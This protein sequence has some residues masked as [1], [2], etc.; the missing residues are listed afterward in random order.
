M[1]RILRTLVVFAAAALVLNSCG[2][3]ESY[4]YD[5]PAFISFTDGT[6]GAYFV[7]SDNTPYQ[8]TVGIPKALTSDLT[9]NIE[10]IATTGEAGVNYDIPTSVT[11]PAGE[12]IAQIPVKGY[13]ESLAGGVK[14]TVTFQLV[15]D[16]VASFDT[17][18]TIV[19]QQFCEF[20][21]E[22]FVGDWTAYE[23]SD[24][25]AD[26]Y[27]P[28]TVTFEANPNGGDTLV[29][30]DIWPYLP[31]KVVFDATD[32]ADFFWRIPDQYLLTHATYGDM[33]MIDLGPGAFSSCDQSMSI[34][35]KVYVAAGNFEQSSISLVKDPVV[36]K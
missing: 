33:K 24:Y 29:T 6:T 20:N 36:T 7:Q 15:G 12:V 26:P 10:V 31:I 3:V 35:Y 14:D 5:G 11:V 8:V 18:F 23:Q 19:L 17:A 4:I 25:E 2:E 34:R 13:F 32:P 28:Y 9:V 1:K 21:V 22:D 30:S 16:L 27:D